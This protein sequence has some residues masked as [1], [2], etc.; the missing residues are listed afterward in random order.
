[1]L[2]ITIGLVQMSIE[3]DNIE[4]NLIKVK[5]FA[6]EASEKK[7][8]ILC[9]PEMCLKGVFI[10]SNITERLLDLA[11]EKN[12]TLAIGI[13][14]NNSKGKPYITQ[15]VAFPNREYQCYRKTHLGESEEDLFSSGDTLP[16]FQ[17]E[18]AKIAFQLCWETHIPELTTIQA[19]KGAEIVF[20]PFASPVS[21]K[22]RKS[23]WKKYL[24]ARAYDN[25]VFICA[26]NLIK[27]EGEK[28]GGIMVFNPK[29]ELIAEDNGGKE[30]MLVVQ[31]DAG[32]LNNLR[33][34]K[35]GNMQGR[36]FLQKRRPELYEDIKRRYN[37]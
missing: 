15:F 25:T 7:V 30:E 1:M 6:D 9:F 17:H 32:L 31:L 16:V 35:K 29:G 4:A 22:R 2:D 13:I 14:E 28:G 37:Q 27:E 11:C 26:C 10:L 36:F 23:I 3:E 19:L 5:A 24:P 18:Q 20:M 21:Y 34:D 12:I 8:D 33:E